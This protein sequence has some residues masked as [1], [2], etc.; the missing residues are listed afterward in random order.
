MTNY[1]S[2]KIK[3]MTNYLK[4]NNPT[5]FKNEGFYYSIQTN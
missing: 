4:K 3:Y 1:F 2:F 5:K